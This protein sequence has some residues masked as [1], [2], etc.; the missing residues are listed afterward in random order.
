MQDIKILENLVVNLENS[1]VG[2]LEDIDLYDYEKYPSLNKFMKK[3][4]MKHHYEINEYLR[5]EG[6]MDLDDLDDLDFNDI[7]FIIINQ[8]NEIKCAAEED[9][10]K[11]YIRKI[12]ESNNIG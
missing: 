4:K 3:Y 12:N 7:I 10:N 6:R 1:L 8:I 11:E 5:K 9:L 2:G